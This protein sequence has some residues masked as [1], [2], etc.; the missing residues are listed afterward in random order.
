MEP[1][2]QLARLLPELRVMMLPGPAEQDDRRRVP[3]L[4]SPAPGSVT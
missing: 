1:R 2:V 3:R 4:A